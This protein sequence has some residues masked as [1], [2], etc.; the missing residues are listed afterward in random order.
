MR[1]QKRAVRRGES[2][3]S[4]VRMRE[5]EH[6]GV[7]AARAREG[8]DGRLTQP[9]VWRQWRAQRVHCTPGLGRAVLRPGALELARG[10]PCSKGEGGVEEK[11]A[12]VDGDEDRER[13]PAGAT[14]SAEE[15]VR[16]DN[17][18]GDEE[19]SAV[20]GHEATKAVKDAVARYEMRE[21]EAGTQP[22][23]KA[24]GRGWRAQ[25]EGVETRYGC[26]E[27]EVGGEEQPGTGRE[28]RRRDRRS[29]GRCC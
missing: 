27:E 25:A 3:C 2:S 26:H 16:H 10:C 13:A 5:S 11:C 14:A 19:K 15:V 18:P 20:V 29:R 9:N 12:Q 1:R 17:G 4:G 6:R 21:R 24:K 23:Q 28:G 22:S 8:D 7:V